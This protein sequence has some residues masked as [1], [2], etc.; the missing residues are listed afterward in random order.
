MAVNPIGPLARH[1]F[2]LPGMLYL[3]GCWTGPLHTVGQ[4][5]LRLDEEGGKE[6][7]EKVSVVYS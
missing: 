3:S 5:C 2:S 6:K 1:G 4:S 7:G